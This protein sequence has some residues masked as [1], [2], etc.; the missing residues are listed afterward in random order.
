[1][2][3][4]IYALISA[5]FISRVTCKDVKLHTYLTKSFVICV[6]SNTFSNMFSNILQICCQVYKLICIYNDILIS[7]RNI[8]ILQ[9][10]I[11]LFIYIS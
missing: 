10:I 3:K 4:G 6:F 9:F 1:M 5:P 11:Q 8:Y 7:L 2:Y